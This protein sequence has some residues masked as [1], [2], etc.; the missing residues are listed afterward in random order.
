M[1]NL[2][3]TKEEFVS[4]VVERINDG[5]WGLEEVQYINEHRAKYHLNYEDI[6]SFLVQAYHYAYSLALED[7]VITQLEQARLGEIN[8]FFVSNYLPSNKAERDELKAKIL[9]LTRR[10]EKSHNLQHQVQAEND[11]GL[12]NQIK[13]ENEMKEKVS[14]VYYRRYPTPYPKLTP[15]TY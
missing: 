3:N 14:S 15:Y 8:K 2:R 10:F 6:G 1:R 7:G 12:E 9:L 13:K 11:M 4:G 5:R